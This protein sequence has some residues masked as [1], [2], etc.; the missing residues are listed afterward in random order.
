MTTIC[1]SLFGLLLVVMCHASPVFGSWAAV[2]LEILVDNADLIV[3]GHVVKVKD[4]GFRDGQRPHDV[5]V[6]QVATV[7]K[8]RFG[9]KHP[10]VVHIGQPARG[11]LQTSIDIR[12]KSDQ[13]GIWLLTKDPQ[14]VTLSF[15][16]TEEGRRFDREDIWTGRVIA[17]EVTL[18]VE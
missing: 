13:Q 3:A 17:N 6:V 5:A 9:A 7:L 11:G 1:R 12:F 10:K 8:S 15:K 18:T 16:N 4:G 2:P 14:R